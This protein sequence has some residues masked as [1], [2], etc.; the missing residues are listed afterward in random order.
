MGVGP[1]TYLYLF[2]V[3]IDL[4]TVI[5]YLPWMNVANMLQQTVSI[6]I[7][8]FVDLSVT[9]KSVPILT[10]RATIPLTEAHIPCI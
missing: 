3:K 2:Q 4:L 9:K 5:F 7:T 6:P 10:K 1:M 8:D